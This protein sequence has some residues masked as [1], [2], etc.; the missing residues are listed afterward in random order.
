MELVAEVSNMKKKQKNSEKE[1]ERLKKEVERLQK[2]L[3]EKE[4]QKQYEKDL[5]IAVLQDLQM[6]MYNDFEKEGLTKAYINLRLKTT[7]QNIIKNVG[8]NSE[9]R[10]ILDENYEKILEKVK[11]IFENDIKAKNE[12]TQITLIEKQKKEEY[13][14]QESKKTQIEELKK[15]KQKQHKIELI[16]KIFCFCWQILKILFLICFGGIYLIFAIICGLANE[17]D[18][19]KK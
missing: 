5:K 10:K 1:Q 2:K 9:E 14:Q 16:K 15:E 4:S 19:K 12:Y 11:K 18:K 7:R 8:E 3:E 6:C 13:Q 17:Q